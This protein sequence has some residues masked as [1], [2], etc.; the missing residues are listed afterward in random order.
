MEALGCIGIVLGI[1]IVVAIIKALSNRSKR[2]EVAEEIQKELTVRC[3]KDSITVESGERVNIY[4]V[5]VSGSCF[6][7]H[8]GYPCKILLRVADIT[9]EITDGPLPVFSLIQDMADEDGLLF[10]TEDI[11]MPYEVSSFQELPLGILIPDAINLAR[12]GLRKLQIYVAI[13]S[14][15]SPDQVF[16]YGSSLLE[17]YQESYGYMERVERDLDMD[18]AMAQLAIAV[19]AADGH[20]D[21]RESAVVRR[22]FEQ[23]LALRQSNG[24]YKEEINKVLKDV[25]REMRGMDTDPNEYVHSLCEEIAGFKEPRL[26][27]EVYELC[28]QIVAADEQVVEEE[29]DALKDIAHRLDIPDKLAGE[30][31][32]RYFTIAMFGR[33]SEDAFLDMPSGLSREEQI[34]FLNR[35]YD[36][37]RSRVT[38]EDAQVR[39]E[40]ELRLKHITRL[41]TELGN[42]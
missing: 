37:W 9:D 2:D 4:R 1:G 17:C 23:R 19:C 8:S 31:H 33:Q 21:K 22:F 35:E 25:I 14:R 38:H 16:K 10:I 36:K 11:N 7:P 13:V 5:L 30:I 27:Q 40:A 3:K 26:S 32:D 41:R 28:A 12:Q 29:V 6:V 42:V 39:T 24:E 15:S 20:I 18:K 34:A